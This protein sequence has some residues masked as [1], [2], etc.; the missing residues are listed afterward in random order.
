MLLR[1]YYPA[2][3]FPAELGEEDTI[4][5]YRGMLW[6]LIEFMRAQQPQRLWA[7]SEVPVAICPQ[8]DAQAVGEDDISAS[9][10]FRSKRGKVYPQSWCRECK[11]SDRADRRK[12]LKHAR[13]V[14][15]LDSE[16]E[17]IAMVKRGADYDSRNQ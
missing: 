7:F 14:A 13:L 11:K 1:H 12:Q 16:E 8:C 3:E 17:R 9:F 2:D 4:R 15:E 10:G 6:E 5:Y